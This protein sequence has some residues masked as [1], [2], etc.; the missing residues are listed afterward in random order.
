MRGLEARFTAVVYPGEKIRTEMWQDGNVVA[1]RC[2]TTTEGK[3]VI[4]DGL[5]ML[6][7]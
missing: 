6:D 3:V 1:F 7:S 5:C 4:D 2:R